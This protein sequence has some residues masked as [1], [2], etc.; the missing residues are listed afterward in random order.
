MLRTTTPFGGHTMQDR[1][2]ILGLLLIAAM[3]LSPA[4]AAHAALVLNEN[5][6]YGSSNLE[7]GY[8]AWED[9]TNRAR[10]TADTNLTFAHASYANDPNNAGTGAFLGTSAS[11]DKGAQLQF[12]TGSPTGQYWI[13]FLMSVSGTAG[14]PGESATM[15]LTTLD[16]L[17]FRAETGSDGVGMGPPAAGGLAPAFYDWSATGTVL[18]GNQENK[19]GNPGSSFSSDTAFAE[20]TAYLAIVKV[21]VGPGNDSLDYWLMKTSDTFGLTEASLGTAD[22]SKTDAQLGEFYKSIFLSGADGFAAYYDQLRISNSAGD[23]GL[24]EVLTTIPEPG[25]LALLAIGGLTLLRRGRRQ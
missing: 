6:D 11:D 13:S 2:T 3:L 5:F 18:G 15:N 1:F 8:G 10:Y 19:S 4:T 17:Q 14:N 23:A 9:T 16:Y 7:I 21:T 12:V 22:F 25:S 24:T 20:S